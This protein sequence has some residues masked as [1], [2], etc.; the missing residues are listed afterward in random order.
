MGI[1]EAFDGCMGWLCQR[2]KVCAMDDPHTDKG[3]IRLTNDLF[4]LTY[5]LI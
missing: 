2:M 4:R 5:Q 3:Y 1:R